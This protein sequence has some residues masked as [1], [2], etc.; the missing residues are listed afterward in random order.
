MGFPEGPE[1]EE[2]A[3]KT[4]IMYEVMIVIVAAL[5]VAGC[6]D[7]VE[8]VNSPPSGL[9][10]KRSKCVI[11]TGGEMALTGSAEDADEDPIAFSWSASAGS[12]TPTDGVGKEVTWKAPDTPGSII[13]TLEVTDGIEDRSLSIAIEVGEEVT[14]PIYGNVTLDDRRYPYILTDDQPTIVSAS[15][16]LTVGPGVSLVVDSEFGGLDVRGGLTVD[17]R[18][19]NMTN[20]GPNSCTGVSKRWGGIY[21]SGG[22]AQASI[23]HANIYAGIDGI[24]LIEGAAAT[25][26]SSN[27]IDQLGAAIS[28]VEGATAAIRSCKI[29]DNG[30]GIFVS[31][32]DFTLM[33]CSIRYNTT[34]GVSV[35]VITDMP[36]TFTQLV[37]ECVVANNG[38]DGIYL[39]GE[40][41]PTIHQC[42]LF[43]NG[44]VS[45]EGYAVR[46]NNYTAGDTVHAEN[47]FWGVTAE[48]EIAERIYDKTDNPATVQ[49]FVG[50]IPWLD[51][52][53]LATVRREAQR[54]ARRKEHT[55]GFLGR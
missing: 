48:I 29:W 6:E 39:V 5:L 40:A 18:E 27:I 55:P 10:I 17:G 11:W 15:S 35:T 31:N 43:F 33:N 41:S 28:V 36:T 34:R 42:A 19:D 14:T 47:N 22:S 50:F 16:H 24:Q 8:F 45:G 13:L 53:P 20:I 30:T 26:D 44:P 37:E 1:E 12:F 52:E 23:K 38:L 49:A 4:L 25:I 21:L 46:L 51:Q 9:A 2:M 3:F 54:G 7:T 32:A